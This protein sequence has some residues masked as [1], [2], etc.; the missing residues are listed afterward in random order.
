MV[1]YGW[2]RC[3]ELRLGMAWYGGVE[4][5]TEP[6]ASAKSSQ[7]VSMRCGLVRLKVFIHSLLIKYWW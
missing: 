7:R 3:G 6:Y 4:L 1:R 2:V 5:G